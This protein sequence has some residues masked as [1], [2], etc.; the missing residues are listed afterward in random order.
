MKSDALQRALKT[1]RHTKNVFGGVLPCNWLPKHVTKKKKVAFIVNTDPSDKDGLHWVA[2]FFEPQHA[3]Y[4]DP[5]GLKPMLKVFKT[6]LQKR[7]KYS[8]FNMRVQGTGGTCGYHC[9]YFILSML[10]KVKWNL[11][12]DNLEFNDQYVTRISKSHFCLN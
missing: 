10:K 2:F 9:L 6:F 12:G 5:Y 7:K 8:Y 1:N 11:S 4:F 3:F